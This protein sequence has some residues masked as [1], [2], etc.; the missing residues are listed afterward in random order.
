VTLTVLGDDPGD[1]LDP[2]EGF[3][4]WRGHDVGRGVVT[5]RIFLLPAG[6]CPG[7]HRARAVGGQVHQHGRGQGA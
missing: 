1:Y 5:H 4:L 3:V 6:E 7:D 2:G